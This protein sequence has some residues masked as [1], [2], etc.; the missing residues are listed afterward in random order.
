MEVWVRCAAEEVDGG[1]MASRGTTDLRL[2]PMLESE[3]LTQTH[4]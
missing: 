1:R 2:V 3:F 4:R